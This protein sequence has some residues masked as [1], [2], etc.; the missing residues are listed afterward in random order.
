MKELN[1]TVLLIA[2][3]A[4]L[5]SIGRSTPL[6]HEGP[7]PAT[8]QPGRL[9]ECFAAKL[10]AENGDEVSAG[11]IPKTVKVPAGWVVAGGTPV[12]F[13]VSSTVL[14]PGMVLCRVDARAAAPAQPTPD[15]GP[16]C[17]D[18]DIAQMLDSGVSKGAIEKA[19][20][21]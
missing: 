7:T 15:D 9:T 2:A 17:S 20:A 11:K 19:C 18:R 16:R 6:T 8:A 13:S 1:S 14:V 21:P 10:W 5:L 12:P 3:L 4:V